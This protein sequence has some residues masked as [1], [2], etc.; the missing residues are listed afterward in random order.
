LRYAIWVSLLGITKQTA[1]K[2]TFGSS[3]RP[4]ALP[5]CL[6]LDPLNQ[7]VLVFQQVDIGDLRL[8]DELAA[9][10][11]DER[12]DF[13]D[14][15]PHAQVALGNIGAVIFDLAV[16]H[17]GCRS[18]TD[19]VA[20]QRVH[21]RSD[22][23]TCGTVG[24]RPKGDQGNAEGRRCVE[25]GQEF[26]RSPDRNIDTILGFLI[27]ARRER[28]NGRCDMISWSGGVSPAIRCI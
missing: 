4:L 25:V 27:W 1:K 17:R 12:G 5:L 15:V 8:R 21:E 13:G 2:P 28:A 16:V 7:V 20:D 22:G 6:V 23:P 14:H 26:I 9:I 24:G 10:E 18:L 11:R 3:A 19:A